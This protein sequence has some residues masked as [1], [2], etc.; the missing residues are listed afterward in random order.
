MTGIDDLLDEVLGSISE[1]ELA[2]YSNLELVE[3]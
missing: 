3:A 1:E 2:E